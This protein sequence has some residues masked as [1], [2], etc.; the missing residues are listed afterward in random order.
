MIIVNDGVFSNL[1]KVETGDILIYTTVNNTT[2]GISFLTKSIYSHVGIAIWGKTNNILNIGNK[3]NIDNN[4][5]KLFIL[6]TDSGIH[7]YDY[8]KNKQVKNN[9][10]II[11]VKDNVDNTLFIYVRKV[12]IIR[13]DIFYKKLSNFIRKYQD[14]PYEKDNIK[15]FSI[16][17][18]INNKDDDDSLLKSAIC[19]QLVYRYLNE[20][21][22]VEFDKKYN[23]PKFYA[24]EYSP[25]NLNSILLDQYKI[26]NSSYNKLLIIIIFIIIILLL[27]A[28]GY[29][30]YKMYNY[31]KN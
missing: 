5:E 20:V 8:L 17:M 14:T 22:N 9:V 30:S 3:I 19:T 16:M 13:D 11:D 7:R 2:L 28:I 4:D 29:R 21:V 23:Y 15:I 25:K 18:G 12:N 26:Y 27:F 1:D 31:V 10:R 6:E 24:I